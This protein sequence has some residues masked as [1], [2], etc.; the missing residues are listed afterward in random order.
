M[1][2]RFPLKKVQTPSL[3][4][5]LVYEQ[6]KQAILYAD[7]QPGEVL[8]I[9]VL[10]AALGT[11][12]MPVRGA[13]S[14]LVAEGALEALPN[15]GL[16]IPVLTRD[17][18][19]DIFQV[20]T[21]LEGL[22]AALAAEV[23]TEAEIAELEGYERAIES[24]VRKRRIAEAVKYNLKFHIGICRA[25]RSVTT[26]AL[27]EALYLRYSPMMFNA[28]RALL[29]KK[30]GGSSLVIRR[31]HQQILDGLRRHDPIRTRRALEND[32]NETLAL[33]G[34]H[35]SAYFPTGGPERVVRKRKVVRRSR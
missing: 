35:N 33:E 29:A 20:R 7:Y 15:R 26:V 5:D 21:T 12:T 24:A 9:R 18:A 32:L 10:A 1:S 19:T 16:R 8:S 13:V 3:K 11:S 2:P 28:V 31:H 23:I 6:L 25:S 34:F 4:Q 27:V 30:A 14:R 17:Q 22:A